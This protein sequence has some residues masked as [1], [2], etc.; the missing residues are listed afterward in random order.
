MQGGQATRLPKPN[1][2]HE[3]VYVALMKNPISICY[4]V[5]TIHNRH[6]CLSSQQGSDAI[7]E[8]RVIIDN[9]EAY[10]HGRRAWA[11]RHRAR[12]SRAT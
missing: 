2:E 10:W 9:G 11:A 1:I 3:Y 4:R 5:A 12:H 6:V 8:N 7:A